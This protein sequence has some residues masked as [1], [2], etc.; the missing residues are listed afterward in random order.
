MKVVTAEAQTLDAWTARP[1]RADNSELNA[2]RQFEPWQN[3]ASL[4]LHS[5]VARARLA[6]NWARYE[7][8]RWNDRHRDRRAVCMDIVAFERTILAPQ[9][10]TPISSLVIGSYP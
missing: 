6:G 9:I 8:D 4:V 10:T 5:P 3:L 7:Y 1:F 2:Y